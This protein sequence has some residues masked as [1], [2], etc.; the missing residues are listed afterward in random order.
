MPVHNMMAY[1]RQSR[2]NVN[3]SENRVGN[4][5]EI[6]ILVKTGIKSGCT[7][8]SIAMEQRLNTFVLWTCR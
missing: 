8:N 3:L 5:S 1:Q 2:S 7:T 6:D 4:S